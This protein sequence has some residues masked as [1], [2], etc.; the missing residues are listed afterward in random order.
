[1]HPV[2]VTIALSA[3]TEEHAPLLFRD[4]PKFATE[5]QQRLKQVYLMP[6]SKTAADTGSGTS[7][8]SGSWKKVCRSKRFLF[9]STTARSGRRND[10]TPA[11]VHSAKSCWKPQSS[12]PL[13]C[14]GSTR[15]STTIYP[16][17]SSRSRRNERFNII[18]DLCSLAA[19]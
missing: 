3:L 7:S 6:G 14:S 8:P 2:I 19:R 17:H 1:V 5:W 18:S 16:N 4:S 15:L 10:T 13:E 11:W 12:Q 9:S